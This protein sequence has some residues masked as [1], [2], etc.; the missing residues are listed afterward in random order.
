MP[1]E[2][3]PDRNNQDPYKF[4]PNLKDWEAIQ[5]GKPRIFRNPK[6]PDT[7]WIVL[8]V[9]DEH[10]TAAKR[11]KGGQIVYTLPPPTDDIPTS[12]LLFTRRDAYRNPVERDIQVPSLM[13][14]NLHGVPC[15]SR[16]NTDYPRITT[17]REYVD[18]IDQMR[19]RGMEELIYGVQDGVLKLIPM[20]EIRDPRPLINEPTNPV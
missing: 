13:Y 6:K 7:V 17:Q 12:N 9:Y 14:I 16:S 20:L 8:H 3:Q 2:S 5:G 10:P 1:A 18:F 4:Y 19:K 15:E 11:F